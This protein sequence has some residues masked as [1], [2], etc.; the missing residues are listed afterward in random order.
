MTDNVFLTRLRMLTDL[1]RADLDALADLMGDPNTFAADR[2]LVGE[3]ERPQRLHILL[4]G[5][6]ARAKLLR[7]GSRHFCGLALPGDV[8]DVDALHVQ[9]YDYDVVTLTACSV[10]AVDRGA[11]VALGERRPRIAQAF[12]WLTF[13]DNAMLNE[14]ATSLA[15]RSARERLGFLLCELMQRLGV[16]GR[17]QGESFHLPLTQE[18][19]A[20]ALGLT[21]VHVNRTMMQLRSAG[22]IDMVSN[23][24]TSRDW[25]ALRRDAGFKANHL[26]LEGMRKAA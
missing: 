15:R 14:A 21:G 2:K 5:W 3:G 4:D 9:V 22:L 13:V 8:C 10:V 18:K 6:A 7:T 12:T 26:H 20:D 17:T 19:I 16:V 11:L 1:D 25:K 24:L 23:Q